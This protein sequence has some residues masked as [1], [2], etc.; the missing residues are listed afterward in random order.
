MI[1]ALLAAAVVAG[2]PGASDPLVSVEKAFVCPESLPSDETRREALQSYVE[3]ASAAYP[4]FGL[5]RLM[6]LRRG[7]LAE[8]DCDQTLNNLRRDENRVLAGQVRD[9]AWAPIVTKPTV[10]VYLSGSFLEPFHDPRLPDD[11]DAVETFIRVVSTV[12]L[13]LGDNAGDYDEL[14]SHVIYYCGS[15]RMAEVENDYFLAGRG[16][17]RDPKPARTVSQQTVYD[18]ED[19]PPQS[20]NDIAMDSLCGEKRAAR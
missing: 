20:L 2:S 9:Q 13:P 11:R 4:A 17:V 5:T 3:T 7:L 1:A 19:V 14:I 16:M 15:N 6:L 10:Q 18:L 12:P 8:H